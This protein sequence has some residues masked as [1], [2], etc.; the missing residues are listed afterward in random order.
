LTINRTWRTIE[1][2]YIELSDGSITEHAA[3]AS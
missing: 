3:A 1:A 2:D